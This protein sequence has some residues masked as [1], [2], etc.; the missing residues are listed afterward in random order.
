ME[1]YSA[2]FIGFVI[3]SVIVHEIV[4][5]RCANRQWIVRLAVSLAFYTAI[6][7]WRIIFILVSALTIWYGAI[8]LEKVSDEANSK[9]ISKADAKSRKRKITAGLILVNLGILAIT[10][11]VLPIM[12]FTIILPLGISYYT[13]MAISYIVDVYGENYKCERNPAKL[14]LY[15]TWFPQILQ[16]PINRYDSISDTLFGS[17]RISSDSIKRN[18]LLFT[19]GALKKYAIANVMIGTVGEIFGGDLSQKPGGFL[20]IGALLYAVCQYADFSGGI[21]MMFAVSGLFGVKMDQNFMQPYFAKSLAEFWRRW[22]ITLGSFMKSYV[23]FPFAANKRIL[24]LN[25]RIGKKLGKHMARSIIGGIGNILVFILVGLWHGPKLH[26]I[27]WGLYNGLIIAVSDMCI[28]V[29]ARMRAFAHIN[30]NNR[31]WNA[32]RI[33]RTFAIVCFAGYFDYIEEFSDSVIAFKNT[34]LHFGPDLSRLW[35]LDLFNSNIL[36]V[37]KVTVFAIAVVIL[38][39]VDILKENKADPVKILSG[40]PAVVRWPVLYIMIILL[41]MSFT[42]VGTDAG[43]MYAAF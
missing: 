21:D 18:A 20:L 1:L 39:A 27:L 38:L 23:F 33:I 26:F 2:A 5:R 34:L 36:S 37:Q 32:F 22:H 3:I 31:A 42:L 6:S 8:K 13:L 16:G 7:K 43:F 15:M 17:N 30:E 40:R 9:N 35:I 11:Y 4:G 10:K 14:L 25:R 12:S 19:F 41:L 28:P 29:F 24:A